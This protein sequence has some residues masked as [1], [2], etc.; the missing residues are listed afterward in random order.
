VLP[1]IVESY[2]GDDALVRVLTPTKV[3]S[4]DKDDEGV[5]QARAGLVRVPQT[6]LTLL[7]GAAEWNLL[8]ASPPMISDL[9]RLS[10]VNQPSILFTLQQRY[11]HGLI[12]T[13]IGS[14]LI[15]LNPFKAMPN[16]YNEE[17]IRAYSTGT[18][19]AKAAPEG[20]PHATGYSLGARPHAYAVS[21]LA[22]DGISPAA[23]DGGSNQ[24][25]VISGESGAGKTETTKHCLRYLAATSGSADGSAAHVRVQN[26]S[27][28]LEAWGNA[29]TLRN[30]NSSRFGKFTEIWFDLIRGKQAIAGASITTYLLEK[31]R[32]V[33]QEKGERNYHVFYQ[34][35]KGLGDAE[36]GGG[37]AGSGAAAAI[38]ELGIR[39]FI[40]DPSSCRLISQSGCIAIDGVDD[41]ADYAEVQ[42]SLRQL[43]VDA[44]SISSLNRIISG[45]MHCGNI[46][47]TSIK[48]DEDECKVG[49]YAGRAADE[50]VSRCAELF[51][52]PVKEIEVSLLKRKVQRG[53]DR[54]ASIAYRAYT[55]DEASAVRDGVAKEVYR[56][57]FDWIVAKINELVKSGDDA[58]GN[59]NRKM[60]GILDIFGFEIFVVNSFEQLCI[61]LCNEVL[62]QHF[63][64]SI[65]KKELALYQSEGILIPDLSFNDNADVI[66]LLTQKRWG[67]LAILDE[68][69]ILPG[70]STVGYM[71][72][73]ELQHGARG[74]KPSPKFLKSPKDRLEEFVIVHYAG[75]VKYNSKLFMAKNKDTLAADITALLAKSTFPFL[76]QLFPSETEDDAE[77]SGQAKKNS[78]TKQ[79]VAKIFTAQLDVLS[80]TLDQTTQ[81]YVRCI[82]PNSTKQPDDFN[83]RLTNEQLLYSG[84][85]E[86]VIVMRNGYPYRLPHAAFVARYHMLS[87][88]RMFLRAVLKSQVDPG[89]SSS[90][91]VLHND[92]FKDTAH[93]SQKCAMFFE[94]LLGFSS[95]ADDVHHV[96]RVRHTH[97]SQSAPD[98]KRP[99]D[100]AVKDNLSGNDDDSSSNDTSDD[101]SDT[102]DEDKAGSETI[103]VP[104]AHAPDHHHHVSAVSPDLSECLVGKTL[105]FYRMR[106]HNLLEDYRRKVCAHAAL[107][108]Q[109]NLRRYCVQKHACALMMHYTILRDFLVSRSVESASTPKGA[110]DQVQEV[111][112]P[113]MKKLEVHAKQLEFCVDRLYAVS[114]CRIAMAQE[115]VRVARLYVEVLQ[116]EIDNGT[117]LIDNLKDM[118][119]SGGVDVGLLLDR[120]NECSEL[121]AELDRTVHLDTIYIEHVFDEKTRLSASRHEVQHR[122]EYNWTHNAVLLDAQNVVSKNKENMQL[123]QLFEEGVE[124]QDE[125]L[126]IQAIDSLQ[127][128]KERIQREKDERGAAANS[129]VAT[130]FW[131]RLFSDQQRRAKAILLPSQQA[132]SA[133][134]E[135]VQSGVGRGAMKITGAGPRL[136]AVSG[137]DEDYSSDAETHIQY[138]C[139]STALKELLIQ[140]GYP[141]GVQ[142]AKLETNSKHSSMA[143][144][145]NRR[146]H[147][148]ID[149]LH[150]LCALRTSVEQIIGSDARCSWDD[151]RIQLLPWLPQV[152]RSAADDSNTLLPGPPNDASPKRGRGSSSFDEHMASIRS[153]AE[154]SL[155]SRVAQRGRRNSRLISA[156]NK[157]VKEDKPVEK[158]KEEAPYVPS[159]LSDI[160]YEEIRCICR[161]VVRINICPL[162]S[163]AVTNAVLPE[164]LSP[165]GVVTDG[166]Q[167]TVYA[168][169]KEWVDPFLSGT[170]EA[171]NTAEPFLWYFEDSETLLTRFL[172]PTQQHYLLKHAVLT[173]SLRAPVD[174][175]VYTNTAQLRNVMTEHCDLVRKSHVD[176][177]VATRILSLETI[178][179]ELRDLVMGTAIGRPRAISRRLSSGGALLSS[180]NEVGGE[181]M[182]ST[183][184]QVE[185]NRASIRRR[186]SANVIAIEASSIAEAAAAGGSIFSGRLGDRKLTHYGVMSVNLLATC[187]RRAAALPI[188]TSTSSWSDLVRWG[189]H[190]HKLRSLASAGELVGAEVYFSNAVLAKDKAI[191]AATSSDSPD[192][193]TAAVPAL[194]AAMVREAALWMLEAQ[195]QSAYMSLLTDIGSCGTVSGVIG[196]LYVRTSRPE[197][198][199]LIRTEL[200]LKPYEGK[201]LVTPAIQQLRASL[202]VLLPLRSTVS[203]GKQHLS[204]LTPKAVATPVQQIHEKLQMEYMLIVDEVQ[205]QSIQARLSAALSA[206]R[207]VLADNFDDVEDNDIKVSDIHTEELAAAVIEAELHRSRG[208]SD[209][210]RR[211][212]VSAE[213]LVLLLSAKV[214]L[215]MRQCIK[216][217]RWEPPGHKENGSLVSQEGGLFCGRMSLRHLMRDLTDRCRKD[218]FRTQPIGETVS[219]NI[220]IAFITVEELGSHTTTVS[221]FF[222]DYFAESAAADPLGD[223]EIFAPICVSG[224][225]GYISSLGALSPL[226]SGE[227]TAAQT[228]SVERRMRILLYLAASYG[229]ITGTVDSG[230]DL[231][232]VHTSLLS[233]ALA[234][235]RRYEPLLAPSSMSG[236]VATWMMAATMM[237]RTRLVIISAA[238]T[239]ANSSVI[240]SAS[241]KGSS[242]DEERA[243]SNSHVSA[244]SASS[245]GILVEAESIVETLLNKS[246]RNRLG[247]IDFSM[248][249]IEHPEEGQRFFSL[250]DKTLAKTKTVFEE[251][252]Q[253]TVPI[254]DLVE[255][256]NILST[257]RG[258]YKSADEFFA[259]PSLWLQEL[260]KCGIAHNGRPGQKV[261]MG[262]PTR[263]FVLVID[264]ISDIRFQRDVLAA[265]QSGRPTFYHGKFDISQVAF[266]PLEEALKTARLHTSL[267]MRISTMLNPYASGDGYG[268]SEAE[269]YDSSI[270]VSAH[271]RGYR[272]DKLCFFAEVCVNIRKAVVSRREVEEF[273]AMNDLQARLHDFEKVCAIFAGE[274]NIISG[275]GTSSGTNTIALTAPDEADEQPIPPTSL[276]EEITL[277]QYDMQR[278]AHINGFKNAFRAG[279]VE[280]YPTRLS[281]HQVTTHKLIAQ[282]QHVKSSDT[283]SAV[284]GVEF[285]ERMTAYRQRLAAEATA[286]VNDPLS[287]IMHA[288]HEVI[289][290]RNAAIDMGTKFRRD[291]S[292]VA[293]EEDLIRSLPVDLRIL[294]EN[295]A[296]AD[297]KSSVIVAPAPG[298][299]TSVTLQQTQANKKAELRRENLEQLSRIIKNTSYIDDAIATAV[300]ETTSLA[301]QD[302]DGTRAT[303][304]YILHDWLAVKQLLNCVVAADRINQVLGVSSRRGIQNA[305][306]EIDLLTE[307]SFVRSFL[308]HAVGILHDSRNIKRQL[309]EPLDAANSQRRRSG[310]FTQGIENGLLLNGMGAITKMETLKDDGANF[311]LRKDIIS[312]YLLSVRHLHNMYV[313]RQEALKAGATAEA[314][315]STSFRFD[316]AAQ[317]LR[318]HMQLCAFLQNSLVALV[319]LWSA[320]ENNSF[321]PLNR[322]WRSADPS[323]NITPR[324]YALVSSMK[325]DN[326]MAKRGFDEQDGLKLT[327]QGVLRALL[328]L[329]GFYHSVV[330]LEV[331]EITHDLEDEI[332]YSEMAHALTVGDGSARAVAAV[333][334]DGNLNLDLLDASAID[335]S[336]LHRSLERI[337]TRFSIRRDT[338]KSTHVNGNGETQTNYLSQLEVACRIIMCLRDLIRKS[339]FMEAF[340]ALD[341][342]LQ[343][344]VEVSDPRSL[345]LGL[346]EGRAERPFDNVLQ[347]IYIRKYTIHPLAAV[348]FS[349]YCAVLVDQR[350]Q[351]HALSALMSGRIC[352]VRGD[353]FVTTGPATLSWEVIDEVLTFLPT[354]V[355]C[356]DATNR[357]VKLMQMVRRLRRDILGVN[358]LAAPET[359]MALVS[360]TGYV[361][362]VISV[363][364]RGASRH[365]FSNIN[366]RLATRLHDAIECAASL[367]ESVSRMGPSL[368]TQDER[369]RCAL[370][371]QVQD[372]LILE[373]KLAEEHSTFIQRRM[374]LL[375]ALEAQ[376]LWATSAG[377]EVMT[378]AHAE[379]ARAVT[380]AK[381]MKWD[382]HAPSE[383]V[384]KKLLNIA[385]RIV[386]LGKYIIAYSPDGGNSSIAVIPFG[387]SDMDIVAHQLDNIKSKIILFNEIVAVNGMQ[388]SRVSA[389]SHRAFLDSASDSTATP[390]TFSLLCT[391]TDSVLKE[392]QQ[393][394]L[395]QLVLGHGMEN[396]PEYSLLSEEGASCLINANNALGEAFTFENLQMRLLKID[397][398]L[399]KGTGGLLA[400]T[401]D[402]SI[403][404]E[405]SFL[406]RNTDDCSSKVVSSVGCSLQGI[407]RVMLDL[408][409]AV[410]KFDYVTA[411]PLLEIL[412]ILLDRIKATVP[413]LEIRVPDMVHIFNFVKA[414]QF[415]R[416]LQQGIMS[417]AFPPVLGWS[418]FGSLSEE[419]RVVAPHS[420]VLN[421]NDACLREA[422]TAASKAAEELTSCSIVRDLIQTAPLLMQIVSAIRFNSWLQRAAGA[423]ESMQGFVSSLTEQYPAFDALRDAFAGDGD[424]PSVASGI[425]PLADRV[426][427]SSTLGAGVTRYLQF[428]L[429]SINAEV[430]HTVLQKY[431]V[432]LFKEIQISGY[433]GAK[434]LHIPA[435]AES[436]LQK[437]IALMSGANEEATLPSIWHKIGSIQTTDAEVC[438]CNIERVTA[439][440]SGVFNEDGNLSRYSTEKNYI[441][442]VVHA[443]IGLQ[444]AL[445]SAHILMQGHAAIQAQR[446]HSTK[447]AEGDIHTAG[448]INQRLGDV[449]S[450]MDYMQQETASESGVICNDPL[451]FGIY[452]GEHLL[453]V[454]RATEMTQGLSAEELMELKEV[455]LFDAALNKVVDATRAGLKCEN[456]LYENNILSSRMQGAAL[457][458]SLLPFN[459]RTSLGNKASISLF[460]LHPELLSDHEY[461]WKQNSF[462]CQYQAYIAALYPVS[463]SNSLPSELRG[464]LTC[465]GVPGDLC[466]LDT[467]VHLDPLWS[468]LQE[469]VNHE[470]VDVTNTKTSIS[471]TLA[472]INDLI[473]TGAANNT[474]VGQ[475]ELLY[476]AV[477]AVYNLRKGRRYGDSVIIRATLAAVAVHNNIGDAIYS[478][479]YLSLAAQEIKL[480]SADLMQRDR[481][482]LMEQV[483]S[484]SRGL[485]LSFT[486]TDKVL[487]VQDEVNVDVKAP[488]DVLAQLTE[489]ADEGVVTKL[490]LY[491]NKAHAL[492]RSV[493]VVFR[494][495][496][497]AIRREWAAL[498]AYVEG[499]SQSTEDM[500][501]LVK[502]DTSVF[503]NVVNCDFEVLEGHDLVLHPSVN[504]EMQAARQV[505][506]VMFALEACYAAYKVLGRLTGVVG[507]VSLGEGYTA[508]DAEPCITS[509]KSAEAALVGL[510]ASW[511][512]RLLQQ[513]V[514]TVRTLQQIRRSALADEWYPVHSHSAFLL[515]AG[516]VVSADKLAGASHDSGGSGES[517][518]Y[519]ALNF[520]GAA[521]TD[522]REPHV[523]ART[524]IELAYRHACYQICKKSLTAAIRGNGISGTVGCDLDYKNLNIAPLDA[525]LRVAKRLSLHFSHAATELAWAE[526]VETIDSLMHTAELLLRLRKAQLHGHWCNVSRNSI[527]INGARVAVSSFSAL[528]TRRGSIVGAIYTHNV[529]ISDMYQ[530]AYGLRKLETAH[531]VVTAVDISLQRAGLR[532]IDVQHP[533][534]AST[535]AFTW[536][537][538][539]AETLDSELFL[540][541]EISKEE[542]VED[543]LEAY[544]GGIT[545][546]FSDERKTAE[547]AEVRSTRAAERAKSQISTEAKA[548]VALAKRELLYREVCCL[549]LYALLTP[550][551]HGVPGALDFESP[552]V[553][554]SSL[555]NA[556]DY[557]E[558]EGFDV[559]RC[560]SVRWL[561]RDAY[562]LLYIRRARMPDKRKMN[563]NDGSG[564]PDWAALKMAFDDFDRGNFDYY[565]SK[566]YYREQLQ[567]AV[568]NDISL[569]VIHP[570]YAELELVRHDLNFNLCAINFSLVLHDAYNLTQQFVNN[571]RTVD[572]V[573]GVKELS[574]IS[575]FEG[576]PVS[577]S[578]E[579]RLEIEARLKHRNARKI[580]DLVELLSTTQSYCDAYLQKGAELSDSGEFKR[581]LRA[582]E[583]ALELRI[584]RQHEPEALPYAVAER[585][586]DAHHEEMS[587]FLQ[588]KRAGA[589]ES[590]NCSFNSYVSMLQPEVHQLQ[591]FFSKEQ[592]LFSLRCALERGQAYLLAPVGCI[593][594]Q[595]LSAA[596]E[597]LRCAITETLTAL[598]HS[599]EKRDLE[600]LKYAQK[601]LDLREAVRTGNWRRVGNIH[602]EYVDDPAVDVPLTKVGD[603]QFGHFAMDS[604]HQKRCESLML[605]NVADELARCRLEITDRESVSDLAEA[606]QIGRLVDSY[607]IARCIRDSFG[608]NS[609]RGPN[610]LARVFAS[611]SAPSTERRSSLA[612]GQY[613]DARSSAAETNVASEGSEYTYRRYL[614][615]TFQKGLHLLREAVSKVHKR[616]DVV[617]SAHLSHHLKLSELVLSLRLSVQAG[618]WN[619]ADTLLKSDFFKSRGTQQDVESN[620]LEELGREELS[621]I[622]A[623][624]RYRM[625]IHDLASAMLNGCVRGTPCNAQLA[626]IQ[627]L[628]LQNALE[629]ANTLNSL[630][631]NDSADLI[632]NPSIL[633]FD[634]ARYICNVRLAILDDLWTADDIADDANSDLEEPG[635][636]HDSGAVEMEISPEKSYTANPMRV[637]RVIEVMKIDAVLAVDRLQL[638]RD[639][640]AE[641]TPANTVELVLQCVFTQLQN[642]ARQYGWDCPPTAEELLTAPEAFLETATASFELTSAETEALVDSVAA[643]RSSTFT[644]SSMNYA[645]A[646]KQCTGFADELDHLMSVANQNSTLESSENG[647][648]ML[649]LL[650]ALHSAFYELQLV[651][652]LLEERKVRTEIVSCLATFG[653]SAG[654]AKGT[655]GKAEVCTHTEVRHQRRHSQRAYAARLS[656]NPSDVYHVEPLRAALALAHRKE[657]S[658]S[659]ESNEIIKSAE[660]ILRFREA[661]MQLHAGNSDTKITENSIE[662]LMLEYHDNR[663][664]YSDVYGILELR[665]YDSIT[666]QVTLTLVELQRHITRGQVRGPIDALELSAIDNVLALRRVYQLGL[667]LAGAA[668]AGAA[669]A[670][671]ALR[672]QEEGDNVSFARVLLTPFLQQ[673]QL[674]LLLREA[675]LCSAQ[676]GYRVGNEDD[677]GDHEM[678]ALVPSAKPPFV[679]VME[680]ILAHL[681]NRADSVP[682]SD[683]L[684]YTHLG[685]STLLPE[686]LLEVSHVRAAVQYHRMR[687]NLWVALHAE[688]PVRDVGIGAGA[689]RILRRGHSRFE[690]IGA[691]SKDLSRC[692]GLLLPRIEPLRRLLSD[693]A[694]LLAYDSELLM[695]RNQL[696]LLEEES[697]SDE[698]EEQGH[699]RHLLA[700]RSSG[701]L[702]RARNTALALLDLLTAVVDDDWGTM[703]FV[704]DPTSLDVSTGADPILHS[705]MFTL[706]LQ[707]RSEEFFDVHADIKKLALLRSTSGNDGAGSSQAVTSHTVPTR[708]I[709]KSIVGLAF[710]PDVYMNV[711]TG[712]TLESWEIKAGG[713]NGARRA[714]RRVS[715]STLPPPVSGGN[716]RR[717]SINDLT[718]TMVSDIS[719]APS[720]GG[721]TVR[722]GSFL[723]TN[724]A[725]AASTSVPPSD[726]H[727]RRSLLIVENRADIAKSEQ[728]SVLQ[729]LFAAQFSLF[730]PNVRCWFELARDSFIDQVTRLRL[731]AVCCNPKHQ[732]Q[733]RVAS[734]GS[735]GGELVVTPGCVEDLRAVLNELSRVLHCYRIAG[736]T[737]GL[738]LHG[739]NAPRER[740]DATGRPRG[741]HH[742]GE[743]GSGDDN[744]GDELEEYAHRWSTETLQ[745]IFVAETLVRLRTAVIHEGEG[746]ESEQRQK[747]DIFMDAD[748]RIDCLIL[749]ELNSLQAR[750]DVRMTQRPDCG[751]DWKESSLGKVWTELL[752]LQ[753]YAVEYQAEL[754]V[755]SCLGQLEAFFH[756]HASGAEHI[757]AD[758]TGL[759]H[760]DAQLFDKFEK[761]VL[762]DNLRN[763]VSL[764]EGGR[765]GS[766]A[767]KNIFQQVE[768][769][770]SPL[771]RPV[772]M[773]QPHP[774]EYFAVLETVGNLVA[775][776][777]KTA[778]LNYRSQYKA[779]AIREKLSRYLYGGVVLEED[780]NLRAANMRAEDLK[781][782][783]SEERSSVFSLFRAVKFDPVEAPTAAPANVKKA[784]TEKD[785]V[786]GN[787]LLRSLDV[788]DTVMAIMSIEE[789]RVTAVIMGNDTEHTESAILQAKWLQAQ[790]DETAC[791]SF[792]LQMLHYLS[793]AISADNEDEFED[794][795][796]A[797][798]VLCGDVLTTVDDPQHAANLAIIGRHGGWLVIVKMLAGLVGRRA[799]DALA[800]AREQVG[801]LRSLR[802]WKQH[803]VTLQAGLLPGNLDEMLKLLQ[804]EYPHLVEPTVGRGPEI[805]VVVRIVHMM[806]QDV[807][808]RHCIAELR[809]Y[810]QHLCEALQPGSAAG[811]SRGPYNGIVEIAALLDDQ[812]IFAKKVSK[813]EVA[814]AENMGEQPSRASRGKGGEAAEARYQEE[815]QDGLSFLQALL[816]SF[817]TE[818]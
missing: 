547:N 623:A 6:S 78:G 660:L 642:V 632:G 759:E 70:G 528:T 394:Q 323:F 746:E 593:M 794:A 250:A 246:H 802:A 433:I 261:F 511:R 275:D 630:S 598:K 191:I 367:L 652:F 538:Q 537:S 787:L 410:W 147:A 616:G 96:A 208:Y 133:F 627:F 732:V 399:S 688:H 518:A 603:I 706:A 57:A 624:M 409:I 232:S 98:R 306:S 214:V 227:L 807:H 177:V 492:F 768:W 734:S 766:V 432:Q 233:N 654:R 12:Y 774:T 667:R 791:T 765:T 302:L 472:E 124:E 585:I 426:K 257:P 610:S 608:G 121:L 629:K 312:K 786:L 108:I 109:R 670:G 328:E 276:L 741:Y 378:L 201:L 59:A 195:H 382:V 775:V 644:A 316:F 310:R 429:C 33:G 352:G 599:F 28:V 269:V 143:A 724:R 779:L 128:R 551:I 487:F 61:N 613:I 558:T 560:G 446:N 469:L 320:R 530:D 574:S 500:K 783:A 321:E 818:E 27:P 82:K 88:R 755:D 209:Q 51:G 17:L 591:T 617:M 721:V 63:N 649:V 102:E 483:I 315:S 714:S 562:L 427:S 365:Y 187:L 332:S 255:L 788:C 480:M 696:A 694:T 643:L 313:L 166:S 436:L 671:V 291:N 699:Y 516:R 226:V 46:E 292:F 508:A 223:N 45:V 686:V 579:T 274:K 789:E 393:L 322:D 806:R 561:L 127:V 123:F 329:N 342:F 710:V 615:T 725:R 317:A 620:T 805:I 494:M 719:S 150:R 666:S 49:S 485:T 135:S 268:S 512:T 89:A 383:L 482:E 468:V 230:F 490:L 541:V 44:V 813:R 290:I 771:N 622:Q 584:A 204:Q 522:R 258:A 491:C 168:S 388:F 633:V 360:P 534:T 796:E 635:Y 743:V 533:E 114:R 576:T 221:T 309:S 248:D 804:A 662:K 496:A 153:S 43:G 156:T 327:V 581:L 189:E 556:V 416:M 357:L 372:S 693:T 506:S 178:L 716:A 810:V 111:D 47:F 13:S 665:Y 356:S 444:Q 387:T 110:H 678:D 368:R 720:A 160:V 460:R 231:S 451:T 489:T 447:S 414:V 752:L 677:D 203:K 458:Q 438:M 354:M 180:V 210:R 790:D 400:Q 812:S 64:Q 92:L 353:I 803:V 569:P 441:L 498:R 67:C 100:A 42:E 169:R 91:L 778:F 784:A 459:A 730:D 72:K 144:K 126:L 389:K 56:R 396:A 772:C 132:F 525:A 1:G 205:D 199:P 583:L 514:D 395:L 235:V 149:M 679:A 391:H 298:R 173:H 552:N 507:K 619:E 564:V 555:Q 196:E 700:S 141:Y 621:A 544:E 435:Q 572:D 238:T 386:N 101:D 251:T 488:S 138:T 174:G 470:L 21:Q 363:S 23:V 405:L 331:D 672:N 2:E 81:Q 20:D 11:A 454:S 698:A 379:L 85:F 25:L 86:A 493:C 97:H 424:V 674:V 105:I 355:T 244:I 243:R 392:A 764:G 705:F 198:V 756:R 573:S 471:L 563:A 4:T 95:K 570:V 16:L 797:A 171:L 647:N 26:A 142:I 650:R 683:P 305:Y 548:E 657:N 345:T 449:L 241:V 280:G 439:L 7:E 685:S 626:D 664:S 87:L 415:R 504:A 194:V 586:E 370:Y 600:V 625:Y 509:L 588:K 816:L 452:V 277:V 653:S 499:S 247:S 639:V 738:Q 565:E 222:D 782:K 9:I 611:A 745:W 795:V 350:W 557:T 461:L 801:Q 301:G 398:Q 336:L 131:D 53:G 780:V 115:T 747:E 697:T 184:S 455:S 366:F 359:G 655:E 474:R 362:D 728:K 358:I 404:E 249:D 324:F 695:D 612:S 314:K 148:V 397:R 262:F 206:G 93:G 351:Q 54:R 211:E 456:Y 758:A 701:S 628:P 800:A 785:T 420:F 139:S 18:D 722:R 641:K 74:A 225:L 303:E 339:L 37:A 271:K 614:P 601:M 637:G 252:L 80:H 618:R 450:V 71:K 550:G 69:G 513:H 369:L 185:N 348:E 808:A 453:N 515:N 31:S 145:S 475:G 658:L 295:V 219:K 52:V 711:G 30:N 376:S 122:I 107:L 704:A 112:T 190:L 164:L 48:E 546:L 735:L 580:A 318:P 521:E 575:R 690:D 568:T 364:I 349:Y 299:R 413:Y 319:C 304:K 289:N 661:Y 406:R 442:Y 726:K 737:T 344:F 176:Y 676:D 288:A 62:Q 440:I 161:A 571:R 423:D 282:M 631:H 188:D 495:R 535:E 130:D 170:L 293:Y 566:R 151:V 272:L 330:K 809:R 549:L 708:N 136:A 375:V 659:R 14:I 338:Y 559:I 380:V 94:L 297:A 224:L 266:R 605:V 326:A 501:T 707:E 3:A 744:E 373:S 134:V 712:T 536:L 687:R 486:D 84:V 79:T 116:S 207:I 182:V 341:C 281:M 300:S 197:E 739:S 703:Q 466:P 753:Q 215:A 35:I 634:I 799:R 36:A 10:S 58:K 273:T 762:A 335:S 106:Q 648:W 32:V 186:S 437:L 740:L 200:L 267:S 83:A 371:T 283:V 589:Y 259:G 140:I 717:Q 742:T 236:L 167:S 733:R 73:L 279:A 75:K 713:S 417:V 270:V 76:A 421:I 760:V 681:D 770:L 607:A 158:A 216:S 254:S 403:L 40:E 381:E 520:N 418:T 68:E 8:Q 229:A 296:K 419:E 163:A 554:I 390:S 125:L 751:S 668:S 811:E 137:A 604:F 748:D 691:T 594:P 19:P 308:A 245:D 179:G 24:S 646:L 422:L 175:G 50:S 384:W 445:Q 731:Q 769:Y 264:K 181:E 463:E 39:G 467:A 253:S 263:E 517:R 159:T 239:N 237:L 193:M 401:T 307:E 689:L 41:A 776:G 256:V 407:V 477:K 750:L 527:D 146:I 718:K 260:R 723:G 545:V 465:L 640:Q 213:C 526:S 65:F 763:V 597:D 343:Q 815:T 286:N 284:I 77:T 430:I 118:D 265:M 462:H 15:A 473:S 103:E 117:S 798:H 761:F 192:A 374:R 119:L 38:A 457:V 663:G 729:V 592:Y 767:T 523:L 484:R 129:P 651:W 287:V 428:L 817:A 431:V 502:F 476:F 217:Q 411:M 346:G 680:P 152:P 240:N 172:L 311:H 90:Y 120:F 333:T 781:K 510:D 529:R 532:A 636:L 402:A 340:T 519:H 709:R 443:S 34:L 596:N 448:R 165:D 577:V 325:D 212:T 497:M 684:S 814:A 702:L 228:A 727:R 22:L 540:S 183:P 385:T 792:S 162:L 757:H 481:I 157:D 218:Y 773:M 99:A 464:V 478:N 113:E 645:D 479:Y 590:L 408:R 285:Q 539:N 602:G 202:D 749:Q 715:V 567:R 104:A 669:S 543:V 582:I 154:L 553:D 673:A 294:L 412:P 503:S 754:M 595:N 5:E 55:R 425:A 29:K 682:D 524:E 692:A 578:N 505:A 242:V 66:E 542:S 606:L 793:T 60:I 234:Y 278:R 675:V 531:A 587:L 334:A 609:D 434:E 361:N 377:V 155:S 777:I 337:S 220:R 638:D 736:T 347:Q 656:L